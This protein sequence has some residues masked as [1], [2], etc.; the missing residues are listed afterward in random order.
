MRVHIL[1]FSSSDHKSLCLCFDDEKLRFYQQK[2]HFRFEAM[3]IK[4]ENCDS[5]VKIA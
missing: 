3:W 4:D 5:V 2:R 1:D